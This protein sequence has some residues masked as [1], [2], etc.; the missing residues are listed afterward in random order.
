MKPLTPW[1]GWICGLL[2]WVLSDQL[3]SYLVQLDCTKADVVPM[4]LIGVT[5]AAFALMGGL[6][7]LRRWRMPG[8]TDQPYAGVRRFIAGTGVLAAG[9]FAL[10][11]L[12][13]TASSYIIPQCHA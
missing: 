11:I 10:A 2:G 7:S 13:Q 1:A 8:Q 5:G 9:I 3:G 12:F 4:T 6:V